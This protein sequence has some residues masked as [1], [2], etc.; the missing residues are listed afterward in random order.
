MDAGRFD[1]LNLAQLKTFHNVIREG[2]YSAA[3]RKLGLSVP[4]VWQHIQSLEQTYGVTFFVRQGRHVQPTD[5]AHRLAEHVSSILVKLDSTFDVVGSERGEQQIRL[6][7]GARMLL[8]DMAAPLAAFH[9]HHSNK[10]VLRH[11]NGARAEELL[12]ADE[13]D[14]GMTL[15]P[16]VKQQ[17]AEIHYEPA[18]TVEFLAVA[19]KAHPYIKASSGGLRELARHGLIVTAEGTHGRDALDQAFHRDGL[20]ADIVAETD[21]SAF[22][23]ACVS[24]GMGVG[25]LAGRPKGELSRALVSR[26]LSRQLGQRR[27]VFMWRKGR[28]LSE[29]MLNFVELVIDLN[30]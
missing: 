24:A 5:A 10:L 8:E 28:V 12:L 11:G 22:T 30:R 15:E 1:S 17:S 7:T 14:I 3:A 18:Y 26:S 6:V 9:K 25:I 27:I 23:L 19:R 4:S 16:S 21:N 20:T 29:P 13:V 2:G